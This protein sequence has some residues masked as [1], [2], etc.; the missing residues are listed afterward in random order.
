MQ[1]FP[2]YCWSTACRRNQ[3]ASRRH[4][5]SPAACKSVKVF[6]TPSKLQS[7]WSFWHQYFQN[8]IGVIILQW[9]GGRLYN[10]KYVFKKQIDYLI[11]NLCILYF[12]LSNTFSP[13][14]GHHLIGMVCACSQS[15][16]WS[17]QAKLTT[18][19]ATHGVYLYI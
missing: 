17:P 15:W 19:L 3:I 4:R 14:C 12:R 11:I 1:C 9:S 18:E 8:G 7:C 10:K 6:E 2:Q 5:K 13:P 16:C